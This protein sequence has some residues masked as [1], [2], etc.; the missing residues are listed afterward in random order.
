MRRLIGLCFIDALS[1]N[2]NQLREGLNYVVRIAD[3]IHN[4]LTGLKGRYDA[5]QFII[6]TAVSLF[7]QLLLVRH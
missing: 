2:D 7:V 5:F 6:I 3:A 1:A 4:A